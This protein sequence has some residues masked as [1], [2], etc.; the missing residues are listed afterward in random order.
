[1]HYSIEF[2]KLT[3]WLVIAYGAAVIASAPV[4]AWFRH[5][6]RIQIQRLLEPPAAPQ[7]VK[8]VKA[9]YDWEK[10]AYER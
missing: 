5:R 1:M 9:P 7:G 6:D 8:I 2:I 4:N 10:E 3:V